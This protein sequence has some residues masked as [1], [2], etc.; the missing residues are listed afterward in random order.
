MN[1]A[2][3]ILTVIFSTNVCAQKGTLFIGATAHIGNG[4]A[5]EN[6]AISIKD[7]KFDLIADASMIRIDPNAFDTIYKIYGKQIILHLFYQ[8]L[9]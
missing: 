1:K 4:M 5:I 3:L 8:I 9:R 6:S 7:G 2:I